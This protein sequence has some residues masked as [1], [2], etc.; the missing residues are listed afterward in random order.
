MTKRDEDD[1]NVEEDKRLG[2]GAKLDY[3]KCDA[4]RFGVDWFVAERSSFCGPVA[5]GEQLLCRQFHPQFQR[6]VPIPS[7]YFSADWDASPIWFWMAAISSRNLFFASCS[8]VLL[9]LSLILCCHCLEQILTS[10]SILMAASTNLDLIFN[11]FFHWEFLLLLLCC[12]LGLCDCI[13]LFPISIYLLVWTAP[14][15]VSVE[16]DFATC[17]SGSDVVE[18]WV[19]SSTAFRFPFF[20]QSFGEISLLSFPFTGMF[21][22]CVQLL[23]LTLNQ[24]IPFQFFPLVV[25]SLHFLPLVGGMS[26]SAISSFVSW[27][28]SDIESSFRVGSP[29]LCLCWIQLSHFRISLRCGQRFG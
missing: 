9:I 28:W 7:Q 15:S 4:C 21:D 16:S 27:V 22:F 2:I 12:P 5:G 24:P 8:D 10:S 14:P 13:L 18:D 20:L 1:N 26:L 25:L 11:L 29:S 6:M 19:E 3:N 17:E 23:L